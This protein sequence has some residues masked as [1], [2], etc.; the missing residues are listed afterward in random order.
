MKQMLTATFLVAIVLLLIAPSQVF[1]Q[2]GDTLVVYATPNSL[3]EIITRDTTS[4]GAQAHKVYK[5]VSLDTTYLYSGAITV[6]S[7]LTVIGVPHSSTG[8]PPCIQPAVLPDNSIPGNLFVMNGPKTKGTFKNL[9]LLGLSTNGSANNGGVAFQISADSIT[10]VVDNTVFEEWLTFA[11][12][13]NGNWDKFFITNCKFRNMVEPNQWYIGEVLRNEWPGAAYTDSV[14]MKYNTMFCINGYAACPVTKYYETY[15]EFS[16]NNV[17][18]TFKNPFFIFNVTKGKINNNIF[19]GAWA[20]GIALAEYPWWDQLWSPEVGSIIDFDV[21]DS[22][23]IALWQPG[24]PRLAAGVVDTAAEKLR[25]VEVKNNVYFWPKTLTDY[26]TAWNDTAHVDSV[27]TVSWMNTRTTNMFTDKTTWPGFTQSGNQ[28]VDPGFGTSI[29][30]V[31]TQSTDGLLDWF[32]LCRTGTLTTT[33]WGYQRTQVGTAANWVPPW[34]LPEAQHMQYTNTAVKNSSTDGLALGDPYWFKGSPTAVGS[35]PA[36]VPLEFTLSQNYPNPFNPSTTILFTLTSAEHVK[37]IVFNM[38]GQEVRTLVDQEM[39]TGR[40]NVTWDG[41]DN[42]GTQLS[43][44]VYFYRLE[45]KSL[46][47]T[48]NMLL[49]K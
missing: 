29:P 44:G 4:T 9:Y 49:L 45:T 31:L 38:L 10:L 13:Y 22:A 18:Y 15:F 34:P 25:T 7:D 40:H 37:L 32:K 28:N 2:A 19:Y 5:L 27:Y 35:Q 20:G 48:R 17:I 43:S 21:L 39:M 11:I 33:Y 3:D 30:N 1:A 36:P 8:R 26:W 24:L 41:R 47:V 12:G 6:K 46:T 14:V 16:H 23:K 42:R